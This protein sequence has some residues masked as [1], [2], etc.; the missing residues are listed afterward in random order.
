MS[1]ED[2]K[3]NTKLRIDSFV[4]QWLCV[5]KN[6]ASQAIKNHCVCVN[7]KPCDKN[8]LM[9]KIGD[10]V[11]F[12]PLK[13]EATE[14][15]CC[16]DEEI[17][18]LF[19][20]EEILVLN[21]PPH[22]V[23]HQAPSVKE[24]TLVDYLK[25]KNFS[26]S[27]ISGEERYGIVHRLDKQT[28]GAIAIAK[29]NHAHQALS[30]QLKTRA[31]GRYYLAIIDLPI[32]E[33]MEVEC[34]LGRNPNHRLKIAKLKSGGRYSKSTFVPLLSKQVSLIAAKLHTGR[35]HQI[36]AHLESVSRHIIG[37]TLYGKSDAYQTRLMLHAYLL[38]L[39]H[40]TTGQ[41][42]EIQAPLFGD[43][44]GFLNNNFALEEV[45]EVINQEHFL[46]L[47]G[48]RV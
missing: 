39:I 48:D 22:W 1:Q 19:E 45:Y 42:I 21:K 26:L 25:S 46:H 14:I 17:E 36:R 20:D 33:T 41:R 35:T 13:Q 8:G 28:S 30:E 29:T 23:V 10:C 37:D 15:K 6:Q 31:M 38:Y 16:F 3:E 24:A 9:L 18:V 11:E 12:V 47:F 27:T 32:K 4:S 5:S 43:M 2:F 34:F 40:P 7:Q 44:L